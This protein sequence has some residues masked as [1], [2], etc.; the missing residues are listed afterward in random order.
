MTAHGEDFVAKSYLLAISSDQGKTWTFM[1]G[2]NLV[3]PKMREK[4]VP[5]FPEKLKLPVIE[6]PQQFK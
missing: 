3:D 6:K 2:G 5:N 1:D 4:L